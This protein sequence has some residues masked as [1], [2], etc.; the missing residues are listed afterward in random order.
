MRLM[1][2]KERKET[3]HHWARIMTGNTF[4]QR[5][6]AAVVMACAW[7]SM[8]AVAVE[9]IPFDVPPAVPHDPVMVSERTVDSIA[10]T[11]TIPGA[12]LRRRADP[13][14]P[15]ASGIQP[16]ADTTADGP[17]YFDW[18]DVPGFSHL[19]HVG[20][21]RIPAKTH[22]LEIP[23]G[24]TPSV[25]FVPRRTTM[26]EDVRIIPVQ[27]LPPGVIPE[28]PPEPFAMDTVT[29]DDPLG[30]P[31][32][33]IVE[34][35][36]VGIRDCRILRVVVAPIR[37]APADLSAEITYEYDVIVTW[38]A[39]DAVV[40]DPVDGSALPIYMI[41]TPDIYA[42][43]AALQ[44]L[45]DWK[46]RKG[47]D[48][49]MVTTSQINP[50]GAPSNAE[51]V[52]YMRGLPDEDYPRYLLIAGP[53]TE[54]NGVAGA[55]F[56]T[57]TTNYYGYTDLD[58]ACRTDTDFYPDL[59]HG[60]LPAN[61]QAEMTIMVN[62]V[63][64]MDRNPPHSAMYQKVCVAG[65][66][67][68]S[69]DG[70]DNVADRLFCE[71]ADSVA[72]YFESNTGGVPYFCVRAIV[73]PHGMTA[74]GLWN[75]GSIL[76]NP[77]NKIGERI[78]NHFVSNAEAQN[79]IN[80]QANAGTSILL[81]RDHGYIH[82]VGWAHPQYLYTHVNALTNAANRPVIFS[83][84]CNSG[85]YNFPN[86]F[87]RAWLA[88]SNGGAYA[89]FAPVD[90][91][92][93]WLNDWLTH[94]FFAG[95]LSDYISGQNASE[96]PEW[97]KDLPDPGGA[98]GAAGSARKLGQVLNFGKF[99]MAEH[100]SSNES[101]FRLFHLFGD[102]ES[103]LRL[104]EP[105]SVTVT[106]PSVLP[107][108]ASAVTVTVSSANSIVCLYSP[109]LGLH[110]ASAPIDGHAVFPLSLSGSGIIYVT[111]TGHDLRPYEAE[112]LVSQGDA[113]FSFRA[114]ALDGRVL[115]RWS[116]PRD[117][118]MLSPFVMIRA[119]TTDYPP[120]SDA[121]RE[122]YEGDALQYLDK[123]VLNNQTYYYSIWV[124]NDREHYVAPPE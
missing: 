29:Y 9:W 120:D 2:M 11:T 121:G 35:E 78:F 76:W 94:G 71:T 82:G 3:P 68:D 34:T 66:I 26:L 43:N 14:L 16:A 74:E 64:E 32:S 101:T 95:F 39:Q 15:G 83:I 22:M 61:S 67:Q 106:H 113:P 92:W 88:H 81:H 73:N 89:V 47:L 17:E 13:P 54:T 108:S 80:T 28:P 24:V 107:V 85:M 87:A 86:N 69:N 75:P 99:Y 97:P 41:L 70:G 72:S 19:H 52:A 48:T 27:P 91:S 103:Q 49:R 51:I 18:L 42:T 116:D 53:H 40:A 25:Q 117:S 65:Q 33:A 7:I 56:N 20:K 6:A 55:Y 45:A 58:I 122:V 77:T 59:Y 8:S 36:I 109:S 60:R 124:T 105:Q 102:P 10:I 119:D 110:A 37:F 46:M 57:H 90:T 5:C 1:D 30:Y 100:F 96:D 84:N 123:D 21:P 23:D 31:E 50:G 115:L 104:I 93:S 38:N 79:R 98:Y 112:I 114:T 44:A 4:G 111:V 12:W 118:G 63:L 62:K